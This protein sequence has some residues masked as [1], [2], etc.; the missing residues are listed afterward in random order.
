MMRLVPAAYSFLL[1]RLIV[2]VIVRRRNRCTYF[3]GI[4]HKQV[5][6]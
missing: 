5:R 6:Y 3:A 2:R 1:L 4:K